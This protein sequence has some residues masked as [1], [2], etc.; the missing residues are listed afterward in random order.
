MKKDLE[1]FAKAD[2]TKY[3]GRYVVIVNKK[4]VASGANAKKVWEEAKKKYPKK[5]S[6]LAKI[7]QD[8]TFVLSFGFGMKVNGGISLQKRR[9]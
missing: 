6:Y 8:E 7:P 9:V 4:V 3:S 2:L 1:W 5:V